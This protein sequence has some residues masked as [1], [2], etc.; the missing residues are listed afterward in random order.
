MYRNLTVDQVKLIKAKA[1]RGQP[2]EE[3]SDK[4]SSI[5]TIDNNSSTSN[6]SSSDS[7]SS[8]EDVFAG[9]KHIDERNKHKHRKVS[10]VSCNH[11]TLHLEY[12]D[13]GKESFSIGETVNP[14]EQPWRYEIENSMQKR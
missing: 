1:I 2:E 9:H 13:G 7:E 8:N 10:K 12:Y 14:L 3:T 4:E 5:K 11:P 6:S